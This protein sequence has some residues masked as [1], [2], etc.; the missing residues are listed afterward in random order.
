MLSVAGWISIRYF[1]HNAFMPKMESRVNA[2][3]ISRW[4]HPNSRRRR[5]DEFSVLKK[6]G[7]VPTPLTDPKD[8][9]F[10]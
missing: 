6:W 10:I 1:S 9:I 2:N 5:W 3:A 8:E 4:V 7:S